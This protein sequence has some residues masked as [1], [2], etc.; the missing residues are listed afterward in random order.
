MNGNVVEKD[1]KY[2]RF[3]AI[4]LS[5]IFLFNPNISIIDLLPDFIGYI[6]LCVAISKLSDMNETICDALAIFKRLIF[7]D[8]AKILAIFW[9]FGLSVTSERNSSL[10]LC[11]F[12]FSILE[13]IF[14]IPAFLK[15]FKGIADLGNIYDNTFIISSKKSSNGRIKR[16][17]RADK[18]RSFTIVFIIIKIA[19]S[20]LP[21]LSD[22]TSTEYYINQGMTNLYRYIGVMRFLAFVPVFVVG[23]AWI[24][25]VIY[26]FSHIDKDTVFI[27]ELNKTYRERFMPR[28]GVFIRRNTNTAFILLIVALIF[29]FDL[30]V[31]NLNML[32][33]AICAIMLIAYFSVL[34]KKTNIKRWASIVACVGYLAVSGVAYIYEFS[35]F[36]KYYY[37]AI[38]RS[39]EAM[40]AFVLY[41]ASACVSAIM[42]AVVCILILYSMKNIIDSHTG[43]VLVSGA[44]KND[45]HRKMENNTKAELVRYLKYCVVATVV[46][47]ATDIGYALFAKDLRYMLLIN[48]IVTII[49]VVSYIKAFSEIM[50][51]VNS[52]Y[53]LD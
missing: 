24:I 2:V 33:D 7:I 18:L 14:V 10:L 36:D 50:Q 34:A 9:V 1:K 4:G 25:N 47:V 15:L 51:S 40:S 48:I 22:L 3:K 27:N 29:S 49:F 26:Y 21:E 28:N 8:A 12:V 13:M 37:G 19:L 11:T 30:R 46:Y 17:N 31:D 44:I 20:L 43:F 41:A 53:L 6:L 45:I 38:F 52:K 39:D 16:K 42:F 5:L 23:L 35:F 32:P